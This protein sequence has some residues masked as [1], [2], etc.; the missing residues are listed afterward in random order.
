[1]CNHL[2]K[3]QILKKQHG[4]AYRLLP[5][6]IVYQ[7]IIVVCLSFDGYVVDPIIQF[8]DPNPPLI[9]PPFVCC[10]FLPSTHA[11]QICR[12]KI[13]GL[14]HRLPVPSDRFF[15]GFASTGAGAGAS[16][17][18]SAMAPPGPAFDH[19]FLPSDNETEWNSMKISHWFW[20]FPLNAPFVVDVQLPCS[21]AKWSS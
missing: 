19:G 11:A 8:R 17:G 20:V 5:N 1:M 10:K 18:A 2:N 14:S 21:I 15:W 6:S 13:P 4:F 16:A 12:W 7:F 3:K 9:D